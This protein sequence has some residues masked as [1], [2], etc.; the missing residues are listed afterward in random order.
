MKKK[1]LQKWDALAKYEKKISTTLTTVKM[2][3]KGL[4]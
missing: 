1:H 3:E 2:I 4:I